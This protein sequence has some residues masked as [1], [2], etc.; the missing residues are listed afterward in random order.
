MIIRKHHRN[1][2]II[3]WVAQLIG[4]ITVIAL[5]IFTVGSFIEEIRDPDI[6]IELK[7]DF[8][9][10]V[11]G[12]CNVFIATAIIISWYKS[13]LAAFLMIAFIILA[14]IFFWDTNGLKVHIPLILSSLLLLFYAYYKEWIMK[15][16]A[17][18]GDDG[19]S[20]E[21]QV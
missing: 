21:K 9:I 4:S 14:N 6:V 16:I 20:Q 5:L 18:S 15:R 12:L 8:G 3:F 17:T 19:V 10:Y 2:R 1:S 7:E 11:F 13:K